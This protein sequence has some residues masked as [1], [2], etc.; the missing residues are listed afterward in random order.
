[1]KKQNKF[2]KDWREQ[3]EKGGKLFEQ[4]IALLVQK[5]GFGY[6]TPNDAFIDIESG[7]SRELDVFAIAGRKIGHKEHYLF[8]ILLV[9]VK[10]IKAVCFM[11]EE[12]MTRYTVGDIH[13]S[14]VPKTIYTKNEE[15]DLTEFLKIEKTH[16]FYRY[17]KVSSQ[18]WTPIASSEKK[19]D[20]FF[21]SLIFPLIKSVVS[22]IN[23]HEKDWYFDPEGEPVNLQ[24]YYPII[25]VEELWECNLTKAGPRYKKVP[26]VG[27]ISHH[28]SEKVSGTYLIDI[29]DKSGLKNLL[30]IINSE[31]EQLVKIIRNKISV[32][33]NSALAE[34]RKKIDKRV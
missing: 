1:M 11:R 18:F 17:K 12:L 5:C 22:N 19:E 25:V 2:P 6:V 14:G 9:A 21:K 10:K 20:Y 7:E 15:L 27:F 3:I 31:I 16:H 32:V 30:K 29:C 4:E 33:E 13:F 28:A 34:A 26:R 24:M 23:E 8:P